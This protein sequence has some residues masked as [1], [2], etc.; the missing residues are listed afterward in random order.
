MSRRSAICGV[1]IWSGSAS[2]SSS[3][4]DAFDA[5]SFERWRSDAVGF[6][7][8]CLINPETDQP[9]VLLAAEKQFLKHAFALD[10]S[11]RLLYPELIYACPKKSGKTTF[12]A[13]FVIVLV[14]L[15][16]GRYAEAICCANDFKQAQ[17]RVHAAIRRIIE[18]SPMLRVMAKITNDRVTLADATVLAIPSG[19]ASAAGSNQNIAGFDELWAFASERARRLFD[20]LVPPPT[21]KIACRLTVSYAGFE[22]E[23]VLLLE[24]YKRGMALPEIAP[25]L[26]AGDGILMFW[27]HEPIAPW[28]TAKWLDDMQRSL[29][30]AQFARMIENRF[31]VTESTFIDMAWWDA[32][33]DKNLGHMVTQTTLP[34][35]V[36]VDASTKRDSTALVA[37][38]WDD[39]NQRIRLVSHRIFQPSADNPVDFEAVVEATL[40]DWHKRFT[41]GRFCSTPIRWSPPPSGCSAAA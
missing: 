13:I 41:S 40:L 29:R 18:A 12:A 4:A 19:F 5:A 32:C 35:Y 38:C 36:G 26:H 11:G 25:G 1:S 39:A 22:G 17:G 8:N 31:T 28:Q 3:V 2:G 16:G 14:M 20:E 24:L 23:S 33:V 10:D 15:H 34:I 7:E 30:P 37:V 6:I 27:S 21:K 9:F